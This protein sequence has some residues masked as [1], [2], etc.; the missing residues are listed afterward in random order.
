MNFAIVS[1]HTP[2]FQPLADLTWPNKVQYAERWGYGHACKTE[3]FYGV[4]LGFEKIWF[5][6]DVLEAYPDIDWLW[7]VGSDTLITNMTVNLEERID[8]N[9][10][11]II[12]SDCNGINADSF[13]IRN[14]PE[15]RS[16]IDMIMS[17]YEQYKNHGWLE[18]QVIIDTFEENKNIIK[19]VPQR[20]INAYNYSLYSE[21]AA[22]EKQLDKLGNDGNWK[23]GDLL[24]HWPGTSLPHRIHLSQ[25]YLTQV[26]E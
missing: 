26:I 24:I 2:N 11:F 12:A 19:L 1:L 21:C 5:I 10:H 13:L 20:S 18:Q 23:P 15:G 22:P 6:K 8:N 25:Y 14:S 9:Y 4:A 3:G 16:Y 7:W 17:K